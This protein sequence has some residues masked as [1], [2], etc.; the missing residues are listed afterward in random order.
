MG[1]AEVM[2]KTGAE[3]VVWN[4][5]DLYER[6]DDP[7]IDRDMKASMDRAD[8]LSAE[9]RGKIAKLDE[10][11][12]RDLIQQYEEIVDTAQKVGAYGYLYWSTET[13]NPKAGALLQKVTEQGSQLNQKLVFME[14]EWANVPEKKA[15]ALMDHPVLEHYKHWL[16]VARQYRPH[17]L[18]EP[19]EKLMSEKAVTGREAWGRFFDET[20]GAARFDF[21]GQQLPEQIVLSKLYDADRAVRQRAA[22]S[23]TAGL[24]TLS[25]T[26]TF[27]FNTLLADK[28][29]D[30]K[31]RNYPHWISSRNLSNEVD[32]SVVDTLINA[33]TSRYDIVARYYR[34]KKRL[35]G[36]DELFDYDRYAP[37]PAADRFYQW[38]EAQEI[39]LNAYGKFHPQMSDIAARFFDDNWIHAAIIP[40]KRGGAYSH[41]VV[42]SA[43]PYVFVNYEGNPREVMTLAHELGH[44]VH[45][46]LARKQGTLQASTPLTTAE[47]ASVFGERLVFEDLLARENDQSVRLAMLTQNIEENLATVFRQIA[48]NRFEHGVHT[49]RREEGELNTARFSE[50]WT[51]CQRA[52]FTDSVTITEDYGIWWSYIPH[53]IQSPGYVYAYS[54]G[55]L[56][57]LALY[58]KYQEVGSSFA[59]KY[60]EMLTSG[61]ID[62][63]QNL[64]KPL[65][66]DLTDPK[67]W[68]HGLKIIEDMV[69]EAEELAETTK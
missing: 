1:Q 53:F 46:W 2:Q 4:L 57:V 58:A 60:I 48:L 24:H 63:P 6:L 45:Q 42:A 15:K 35:L 51:E 33:V 12:L 5:G 27:V 61:S 39:V 22:A 55:N 43:H 30:D 38:P 14:I 32:D 49:A 54:F 20:L 37:L 13:E 26:M 36:L 9:Y 31:L 56:L 3:E 44:G 23:M 66:V 62:W 28:A 21:E 10:E 69:V 11:E 68:D 59:E 52:M 65:G 29:S 64:V 41:P 34:L 25:R 40:G 19:E 47:T 7:A 17:L 16:E 18:S 67:F 8:K 50:I